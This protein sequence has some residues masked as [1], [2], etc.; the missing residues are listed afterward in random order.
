MEDTER[1]VWE[2]ALAKS[3]SLRE[4]FPQPAFIDSRLTISYMSLP[5]LPSIDELTLMFFT[6]P[7]HSGATGVSFNVF[8]NMM[9]MI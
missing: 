9:S 7:F 8:K 2:I 4:A 1:F 6:V 3:W 5:C